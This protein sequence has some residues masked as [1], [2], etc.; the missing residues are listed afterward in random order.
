MELNNDANTIPQE[1]ATDTTQQEAFTYDKLDQSN[2]GNV[3]ENSTNDGELTT[4]QKRAL[5]ANFGPISGYTVDEF[6]EFFES[7]GTTFSE[8]SF[9]S[10]C[11][12]IRFNTEAEVNKFVERYDGAIYRSQPLWARKPNTSKTTNF[13]K[14]LHIAGID[15]AKLSERDLFF[16]VAPHGFIEFDTTKDINDAYKYLK[17]IEQ[18]YKGLHV[19][20]A[21]SEQKFDPTNQFIP[22]EDVIPLSHPFW[23]KLQKMIFD[24]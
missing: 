24:H 17:S 7:Q 20:Y 11:G 13:V 23:L 21:R 6:R 22:L 9:L 2:S 18:D 12:L 19:S 15:E 4:E 1:S 10:H 14:T 5:S 16:L 8:I 3:V